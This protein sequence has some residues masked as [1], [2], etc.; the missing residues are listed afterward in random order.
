MSQGTGRCRCIRRD[1]QT[2]GVGAACRGQLGVNAAEASV[3]LS[4]WPPVGAESVDISD[5]YAQLAAR[6][7]DYGPAF[8]G[9]LAI[10][11][12]GRSFSPRWPL[13]PGPV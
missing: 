11:R 2:E 5:G 3:D 6:G 7:Y 4:V 9:L 10:W 1:D 12:R 8:Q 13:L